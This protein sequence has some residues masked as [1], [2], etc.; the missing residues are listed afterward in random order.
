MCLLADSGPGVPCSPSVYAPIFAG[1][2]TIDTVRGLS[3]ALS[4]VAEAVYEG[5]NERKGVCC[6]AYLRMSPRPLRGGWACVR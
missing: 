1:G 2:K 6:C 3:A 5:A 4:A